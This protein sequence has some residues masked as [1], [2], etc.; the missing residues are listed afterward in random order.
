MSINMDDNG[1]LYIHQGDSASV[2]LEGLGTDKDY[3]VY[4]AV[5][6]K[7]RK[8]IGDELVIN[9]NYNPT[10]K[11]NLSGDYTDLFTVPDN[12]NYAIYYYALK[13]CCGNE[14]NTLV[15]ENSELGELNPLIVYPKMV[16]GD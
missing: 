5:K 9:S 3:R 2:I 4:F 12:E 13:I 16:E 7:S 1:T 15:L 6:D 10:V 8:T 11:F 14:E